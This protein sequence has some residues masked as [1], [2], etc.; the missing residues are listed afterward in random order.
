MTQDIFARIFIFFVLA[1]Y[2]GIA[3]VFVV[4]GIRKWIWRPLAKRFPAGRPDKG[5]HSIKSNRQEQEGS[6]S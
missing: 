2:T 3:L 4:A 1:L 6:P 5:Y